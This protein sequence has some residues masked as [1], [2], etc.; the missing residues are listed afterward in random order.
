MICTSLSLFWNELLYKIIMMTYFTESQ[1]PSFENMYEERFFIEVSCHDLW[2]LVLLVATA[3]Y[4]AGQLV[5]LCEIAHQFALRASVW[6][7]IVISK[8]VRKSQECCCIVNVVTHDYVAGECL[9]ANTKL[10]YW[11]CWLVAG[12]HLLDF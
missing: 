3:L 4:S 8:E 11:Y 5:L 10:Y 2:C 12:C 6:L 7:R 1:N 9:F